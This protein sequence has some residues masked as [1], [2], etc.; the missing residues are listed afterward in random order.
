MPLIRIK[1]KSGLLVPRWPFV[2]NRESPQAQGLLG[3]WPLSAGT[4]TKDLAGIY[5][6]TQVGSPTMQP[7][8]GGT[9]SYYNNYTDTNYYSVPNI[10]AV[11]QNTN[12]GCISVWCD[13]SVAASHEGL[14]GF[15]NDLNFDFY[16]AP[17][18]AGVAECRVRTNSASVNVNIPVDLRNR[19]PSFAALTYNGSQAASYL[20]GEVQ[21]TGA[22]TGNLGPSTLPLQIGRI[23]RPG[24]NEFSILGNVWDFRVYSDPPSAEVIQQAYD[25]ATRWDLY[26]ELGRRTYF[27]PAVVSGAASLAADQTIAA[28]ASTAALAVI[29]KLSAAQQIAAFTSLGILGARTRLT[30]SNSLADFVAAA[31][32]EVHVK[33]DGA[34]TIPAVVQS[35]T[36]EVLVSVIGDSLIP[37]VLSAAVVATV[38]RLTAAQQIA[39]FASIGVLSN[40]SNPGSRG[41]IYPR[42]RRIG[43]R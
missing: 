27:F 16:I 17:L 43:R 40:I 37:D 20:D 9:N 24:F 4:Q 10:S 8:K 1:R 14:G 2:V 12:K 23:S 25:P 31:A 11:L 7:N 42:W 15:R 3:W 30:A 18:L 5:P 36:A 39:D 35:A 29:E 19:G 41:G 6:A 28:F 26:Y 13:I 22:Q 21:A 34:S 38:Q 32:L 33:L